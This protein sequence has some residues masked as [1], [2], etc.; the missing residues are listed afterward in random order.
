MRAVD[1]LVKQYAEL[2]QGPPEALG[3]EVFGG[4]TRSTPKFAFPI[5]AFQPLRRGLRAVL[6]LR[7]APGA[8]IGK[9]VHGYIPPPEAAAGYGRFTGA[10]RPSSPNVGS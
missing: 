1:L 9:S 3:K 6:G 10:S 4:V 5:A 8:R 2:R 7:T